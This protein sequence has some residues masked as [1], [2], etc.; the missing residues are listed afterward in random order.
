MGSNNEMLVS[1]KQ[2]IPYASSRKPWLNESSLKRHRNTDWI[3]RDTTE[4]TLYGTG[5]TSMTGGYKPYKYTIDIRKMNHQ[6][7]LFKAV[8][9][10]YTYRSILIVGETIS[11]TWNLT[12][13]VG[14]I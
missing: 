13:C 11:L 12:Q 6:T 5:N 4:M 10:Q 1:T 9:L 7:L 14:N 3:G 2:A 8:Y